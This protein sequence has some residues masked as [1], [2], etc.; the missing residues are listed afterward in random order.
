[1]RRLSPTPARSG[2]SRGTAGRRKPARP[3][4][5]RRPR[6]KWQVALLRWGGPALG[7]AAVL[8]AG[9]WAW[10]SG[11]ADRQW[12]ALTEA[13]LVASGEA[14]LALREVL[15]QGR[16]RTSQQDL[17]TALDLELGTPILSLDPAVL[18][19]R[20]EALPWVARATVERRLPDTL[21]ISV[22][23]REP[24]ALW[25]REGE[26]ALIDRTGT[27]IRDPA[28]Q[29]FTHLPMVVGDG[30]NGHA[31]ELVEML[32][33]TPDLARRVKAAIWVGDRRWNIRL[34]NGVDVRL[35]EED[36]AG[37]WEE[38]ANLQAQHG[39]IDRD[40]SAIDLRQPDRLIVRLTPEAAARRRDPG[41][42]T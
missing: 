28:L 41:D 3:P 8:G 26:I 11:W 32:A 17:M 39:L 5:R 31:A 22:E 23:E 15:V 20:L 33:L 12:T 24:L 40:L 2:T 18:R 1:M 38:L 42:S 6:A 25:Q 9:S 37:A 29:S 10:S 34:D 36:G 4:A 19:A 13:T 16:G 14:G 27:V 35:P 30:A 7:L 21:F